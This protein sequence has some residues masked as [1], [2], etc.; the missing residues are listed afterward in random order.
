[1]AIDRRSWNAVEKGLLRQLGSVFAIDDAIDYPSCRDDIIVRCSLRMST[2]TN[3]GGIRATSRN[4]NRGVGNGDIEFCL[5]AQAGC[6]Y[7]SS[8]SSCSH[9]DA[10]AAAISVNNGVGDRNTT[11]SCIGG[12]SYSCCIVA[13]I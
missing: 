3:V 1:M 11:H 2:C 12:S 13:D 8:D 9:S 4:V 5:P 6:T 10:I 7:A